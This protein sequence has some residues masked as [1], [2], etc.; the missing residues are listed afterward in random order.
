MTENLKELRA[1]IEATFQKM[2][3]EGMGDEKYEMCMDALGFVYRY[4][5]AV[6]EE[7]YAYRQKHQVGHLPQIKGAG[8]MTDVLKKLGMDGDYE[9]HKPMISVANTNKGLEF[10]AEFKKEK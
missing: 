2:K 1:S 8:K 5:A 6:E 3:A 4:V 10:E 7:L 9:V